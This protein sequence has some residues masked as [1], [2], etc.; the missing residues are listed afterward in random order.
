MGNSTRTNM[1]NDDLHL[2]V[3]WEASILLLKTKMCRVKVEDQ[4]RREFGK[5]LQDI[6]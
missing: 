3:V 1:F 4:R 2:R 5:F 6:R